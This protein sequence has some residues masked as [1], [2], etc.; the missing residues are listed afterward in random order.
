MFYRVLGIAAVLFMSAL[1]Q[2]QPPIE[3]NT[4]LMRA[5]VRLDGMSP[6][7]SKIGTGFIMGRPIPN[8]P[9]RAQYVLITANH[10]LDEVKS[11]FVIMTT[12]KPRAPGGWERVS[13]NLPI[14]ALVSSFRV[15]DP[16]KVQIAKGGALAIIYGA[17]KY[18]LSLANDSLNGIRDA[19]QLLNLGLQAEILEDKGGLYLRVYMSNPN[20]IAPVQLV[21]FAKAAAEPLLVETQLWIRHPSADIAAMYIGLPDDVFQSILP[22]TLLADDQVL[23]QYGLHP[24]DEL[25]C[26]GYPL[27]AEGNPVGFPVLRSGKIASYP[28]LPTKET[29]SFLM[30]FQVFGGNSGGPVYL[31]QTGGTR[32]IDGTTRLGVTFQVIIGLVSEE[33]MLTQQQRG[34][35]EKS[36]RQYPLKLAKV[37]H[38]SLIRDTIELLPPPSD[39]P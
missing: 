22:T 20:I 30:D 37:V 4:E 27:G 18:D 1:A 33:I 3:L 8:N 13:I 10:V 21:R 16:S 12:R 28:L 7:G 24:G 17:T 6:E 25:N 15:K 29:A 2:N 5:T 26:L 9:K 36:E 11:H 32:L 14:R 19:I 23:K 35:Y 38:A 39:T 34:L 31:A